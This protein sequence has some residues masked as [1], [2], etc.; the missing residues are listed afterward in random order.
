MQALTIR[1]DARRLLEVIDLP[2]DEDECFAALRE[3]VGGPVEHV[4]LA[5]KGLAVVNEEGAGVLDRNVPATLFVST[6]VAEDGRQLMGDIHG[7]A[8]ICAFATNGTYAPI[9]NRELNRALA[10]ASIIGDPADG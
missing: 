3:L 9:P 8:V 5:D 2:D 7:T 1:T 4:H 10:L 6:S